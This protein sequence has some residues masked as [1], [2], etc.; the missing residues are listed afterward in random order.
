MR[1][2]NILLCPKQ[3]SNPSDG[4]IALGVQNL[5]SRFFAQYRRECRF[6]PAAPGKHASHHADLVVAI[7][8]PEWQGSRFSLLLKLAAGLRCPWLFVGVDHEYTDL[9][10]APVELRV[11]CGA[12][13]IARS[14]P[15]KKVLDDAG[16]DTLLLPCPSLFVATRESPSRCMRSVAVLICT[17][18]TTAHKRA[19]HGPAALEACIEELRK[20]YHVR[21][22]CADVSDYFTFAERWPALVSFCPTAEA[23]LKQL[24]LSDVTITFHDIGAFLAHS[25]LKPAI[26]M[27]EDD[28]SPSAAATLFPYLLVGRPDTTLS[29][30]QRLDIDAYPRN[31]L[32]WKRRVEDLYL[33]ALSNWFPVHDLHRI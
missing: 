14:C 5:L 17:K 25:L 18:R 20:R 4:W 1:T 26:L 31:L 13:V 28:A 24:L 10:L 9:R 15:A 27:L 3:A 12:L 7:G 29:A 2:V 32:N 30:L 33:A 11:L 8:T 16:I 21:I 19:V 22:L 23:Q 6:L